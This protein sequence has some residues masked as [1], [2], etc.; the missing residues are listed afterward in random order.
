M[1]TILIIDDSSTNRRI[2]SKLSRQLETNVNVRTFENPRKALDWM[3]EN[4]ADLII[5]DYKMP[6]MSGA[7][8]TAAVRADGRDRDVPIIVIT[9]YNDHQYRLASLL[10]G[11]TDFLLSPV[12]HVEFL[13][14]ARNLLKLRSQQLVIARRADLLEMS[15]NANEQLLRE[16]RV[17]LA[18]V[19][20]TVPAMINA[21]DPDGRCVFVNAQQ[22]AFV[23][24]APGDL[25]GQPIEALLGEERGHISRRLDQLVLKTGRALPSR[26]EEVAGPDG[27]NRIYLTSKAPLN[28]GAG[29]IV[30]I[31]TTSI[32]ITE[33]RHAERR[34]QHIA[35][36]DSLTGLPNR[37][38][39]RDHLRR[40][41]ARGR[42][43]DQ[44][45][46][47][48]FIDLDRFKAINDA[49]GHHRGDELLQRVAE[50]L[51]GLVDSNH[52]VARLG[53]DEF[54]IL[55]PDI[56]G[57][58]DAG[59]LAQSILALLNSE[60]QPDSLKIGAS[61]GVTLAPLDGTDPDELLK[62]SDQA[63]Y[64]AK[65]LGGSTWRFFA[66]DMRPRASETAQLEAELRGALTRREFVLYYQPQVDLRSGKV[67]GA[68][69]LLR[70]R[71]PQH[72]LLAPD[73]FL[74]LAEETGLIV[75]I[76]EWVLKEAC[77]QGAAWQAAGLGDLR[78]AV[79]LSPI[80]F[81]RLGVEHLIADALRT[82][83]MRPKSL[84][85]ELTEGILLGFDEQIVA[86]MQALRSLGVT[87]SLDDFGT[88]YSSLSYI[89]SFP[90]DR[91]K[92]DR[93]FVQDLGSDP[94]A[95]AIVRTII[96]LGHI[97]HLQVLAE[98]VEEEPQLALLRA[99]GCDEVQGYYFSRPIP[100]DAFVAWLE[101]KDRASLGS[102]AGGG[103]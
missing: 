86:Q 62:N 103:E 93:S 30:S 91:L 9:A 101:E 28:D 64:L 21:T 16:S 52:T 61:I 44:H 34:L 25:V 18:Q 95:L 72:G 98:G 46:A 50:A 35:N 8:L 14:R 69:A 19:I 49:Q 96:D 5:T 10:A 3:A 77:Q 26:E 102:P 11:A 7:E 66:A 51:S 99:E 15:L 65:S 53:G 29:E 74:G 40:E 33:R 87:L 23:G 83:G 100:A 39:L 57:P 55:Q 67:V 90:L 84:E 54:A 60:D 42:R 1:S 82:S 32:D 6:M 70:W 88:G 2:Y 13:A 71:H 48:H 63:M 89:R 12:D 97:L 31:L 92:I 81:R 80:Q 76:N 79:N 73:A 58:E 45:F 78:I 41:L 17:A 4:T 24:K 27:E 37:M 68:E 85:L 56:D 36:H 22:A 59:R 38:M 43:G 75:P 94:S 20:D 47:L